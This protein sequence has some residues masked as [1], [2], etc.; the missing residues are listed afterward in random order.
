MK[1]I[2]I[3]VRYDLTAHE[4]RQGRILSE[5]QIAVLN[6]D[7]CE[8][9]Q[10]RLAL[11]LDTLNPVEF[12]QVEAERTGKVLYIQSLLEQH[13]EALQQLAIEAQDNQQEQ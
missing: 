4:E 9:L 11:R 7:L 1:A 2:P 3:F 13:E 5:N 8:A 6:N 10:Q 12:A